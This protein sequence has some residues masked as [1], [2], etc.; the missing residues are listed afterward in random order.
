VKGPQIAVAHVDGLVG[1]TDPQN[2]PEFL[3]SSFVVMA[4]G[5]HGEQDIVVAKAVGIA[6]P[7]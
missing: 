6:I 5:D 2:R 7:V 1:G 3:D 4:F